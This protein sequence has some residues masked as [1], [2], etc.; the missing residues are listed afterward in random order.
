M[1]KR[2]EKLG[3]P[4]SVD[5]ALELAKSRPAFR[6]VTPESIAEI[7]RI[8]KERKMTGV[9]IDLTGVSTSNI[10]DEGEYRCV[11]SE[12]KLRK[13]QSG[14]K[15]VNCIF[16]ISDEE[17]EEVNGRKLF[18]NYTLIKESFFALKRD[19][20]AIGAD[21]EN[22]EGAFDIMEMFSSLYGSAVLAIVTVEPDNRDPDTLR[23]RVRIKPL[24]L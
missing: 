16:T 2:T 9:V 13:A 24:D 11:L 23:N 12:A 18:T 8:Q 3:I 19:L 10:V 7:E 15:T 5:E 4:P 17:H 6:K 1:A 14:N 20:I 22:L 21:P